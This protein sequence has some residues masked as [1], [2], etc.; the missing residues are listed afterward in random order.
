M[1]E[2]EVST[3]VKAAPIKRIAPIVGW[4]G[5]KPGWIEAKYAEGECTECGRELCRCDQAWMN[6]DRWEVLGL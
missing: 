5:G 4:I 6:C 2:T 1:V 3:A